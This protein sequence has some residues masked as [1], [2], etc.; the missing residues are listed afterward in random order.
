MLEIVSKLVFGS[1]II[2]IIYVIY[3]EW[4]TA[5]IA[6]EKARIRLGEIEN[7]TKVNNLTPDQL[8]DLVNNGSEPSSPESSPPK[9]KPTGTV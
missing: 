5:K 1:S 2:L 7:E 8:I 3:Y 6:A 9:G 4:K